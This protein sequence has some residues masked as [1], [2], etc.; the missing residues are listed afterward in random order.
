MHLT[1]AQRSAL[2]QDA[3]RELARRELGEFCVRIDPSYEPAPHTRVLCDRLEAVERG[4]I[5]RLAVFMPPRHSKTYHVSE[6]FP[7]WYLGRHPNHQVILASYGAERAED[8]SRKARNLMSSELWPFSV[9]VAADSSAVNRWHTDKGG[10]VMAAG[11]GGAMTGFGAHLLVIDDPVKNREEADSEI[12]RER[13]W[14]WY[15]EVARTRLMPGGAIVLCQT[16]WHE[17]DLAGRILTS[18]ASGG[19]RVLNLP[20]LAEAGDPLG[21]AEGDPLWPAWFDA[22]ELLSLQTDL[23]PRS[24]AALYQQR[25]TSAEGGMF[26]RSWFTRR[27]TEAQRWK[28][29]VLAVDSAFKAGVANDYSAL[30]TWATDG[31]DYYLLNVIRARVEFPELCQLI[32]SQYYEYRP[33]AVL[34]EDTASG[35]VAIQ[36]LKRSSP[37]PIVPIKVTAS[38]DARAQAVSPICEAGKVLLPL[39]A[40]W[41]D[42]WINEH[43]AFP[44]GR[45]DDMVDTTSMG[46]ARLAQWAI[47]IK[48]QQRSWRMKPRK[49][50]GLDLMA[51][52]KEQAWTE[53]EAKQ[54]VF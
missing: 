29:V 27:W 6:R 40:A 48:D 3:R 38:K 32:S 5:Q 47:G 33:H 20:A 10:V 9:K 39:G 14:G 42:D 54:N 46:L 31:V 37:M 45:H 2:V 4:E 19:W 12:I 13:A 8:A 34:I 44:A 1:D 53:S 25:P 36:M 17:D 21:R 26:K 22:G 43:A 11:V 49:K 15:A 23:G 35:Q 41:V 16:R 30:A 28:S 18:D 52:I 24:W 51:E 7:A 50:K